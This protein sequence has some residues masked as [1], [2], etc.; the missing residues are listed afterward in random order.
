MLGSSDAAKDKDDP[1]ASVVLRDAFQRGLPAL[2]GSS[3]GHER[4]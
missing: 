4:I 1:P 2:F 3:G